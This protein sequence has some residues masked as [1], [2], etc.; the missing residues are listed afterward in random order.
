MI[1]MMIIIRSTGEELGFEFPDE[2]PQLS[3]AGPK[4]VAD[5]LTPTNFKY[6]ESPQLMDPTVDVE[7]DGVQKS[8]IIGNHSLNVTAVDGYVRKAEHSFKTLYNGVK[9]AVLKVNIRGELVSIYW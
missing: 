5:Y 7:L 4:K 1:M 9:D 6:H 2:A 8:S 3:L